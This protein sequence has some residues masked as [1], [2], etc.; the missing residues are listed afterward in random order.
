VKRNA[1]IYGALGFGL[2]FWLFELWLTWEWGEFAHSVIW[3]AFVGVV[4]IA[5][6]AFWGW[7]MWH[8]MGKRFPASREK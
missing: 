1:C 7:A 5:G 2:P 8:L 6:G 4:A 3:I